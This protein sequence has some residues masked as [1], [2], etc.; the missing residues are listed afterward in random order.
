MTESDKTNENFILSKPDAVASKLH[1]FGLRK[2]VKSIEIKQDTL[3]DIVLSE[4]KK[5]ES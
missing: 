5:N 3:E 2:D 4:I 1:E